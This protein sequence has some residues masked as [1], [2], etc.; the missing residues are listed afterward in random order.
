MLIG[1]CKVIDTVCVAEGS[2]AASTPGK[3]APV[4][5]MRHLDV[6]EQDGYLKLVKHKDLG[7]CRRECKTIAASC[8]DQLDNLDDVDELQAPP[9]TAVRQAY[10]SGLL[11]VALWKGASKSA[12]Q[13]KLCKELTSVC[14]K[15]GRVKFKGKTRVDE[16]F[17]E[18]NKALEEQ[19]ALMKA[20]QK[21]EADSQARAAS[22][23]D[24]VT[25]CYE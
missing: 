12:V 5:W 14:S 13:K 6:V 23:K 7:A 25:V 10:H 22:K 8:Q 18:Q 21:S 2:K 1:C 20:A 16:K 19:L 9:P 24:K 11:Q 15:K 3:L 4:Q 17:I